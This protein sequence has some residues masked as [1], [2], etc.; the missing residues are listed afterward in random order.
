[1][2]KVIEVSASLTNTS[3]LIKHILTNHPDAIPLWL[4]P[5][6]AGKLANAL[7]AAGYAGTLAGPGRL[8]SADFLAAA[9]DAME[10]FR[11]PGPLLEKD[12]ATACQ[13]FADAF[14]ARFSREPDTTAAAAYDAQSNQ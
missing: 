2:E 12:A 7:R 1:L 6:A 5:A 4:D 11:V 8:R 14:R 10:G 9:G 13:P 3:H